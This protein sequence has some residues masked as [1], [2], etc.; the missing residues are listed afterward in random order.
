[1][2]RGGQQNQEILNYL[3]RLYII[4]KS[5]ITAVI[6]GLLFLAAAYIYPGAQAQA[7]AGAL[8]NSISSAKNSKQL[9]ED[10]N[11]MMSDATTE[12]AKDLDD[13]NE[14]MENEVV[15][16]VTEMILNNKYKEKME[17]IKKILIKN[18]D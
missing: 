14:K 15:E 10:I 4:E 8:T 3:R 17:E 12:K 2:P 5:V 11:K 13:L 16:I 6:L 18:D 9:R 1:M 7:Q